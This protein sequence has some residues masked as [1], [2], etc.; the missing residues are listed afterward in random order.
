MQNLIAKG[1]TDVETLTMPS[2]GIYKIQVNVTSVTINDIP[3]A[4]RTGMARGT[5]VIPSVANQEAIPE[6][7]MTVWMLITGFALLMIFSR[8]KNRV[9]LKYSLE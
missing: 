3:D 9:S 2:N 8:T 5:I 1:G 6:F 7:P 4:S